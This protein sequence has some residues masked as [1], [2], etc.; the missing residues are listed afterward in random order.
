[1]SL[2]RPLTLKYTD[3]VTF[4]K[5]QNESVVKKSAEEISRQKFLD[6]L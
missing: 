3:K 4:E 5:L 1:M 6:E 2:E